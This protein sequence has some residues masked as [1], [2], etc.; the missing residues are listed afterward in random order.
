MRGY[1]YKCMI[2]IVRHA[3]KKKKEERKE[4]KKQQ[5]TQR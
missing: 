4:R 3:T 1:Q 2:Y 5:E